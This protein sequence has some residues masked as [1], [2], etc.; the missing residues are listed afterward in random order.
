MAYPG[1]ARLLIDEGDDV[2]GLGC[3]QVQGFLVVHKL[4]VRPLDAFSIVLFLSI[5]HGWKNK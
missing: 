4:D 3:D 2:H 5:K 1:E